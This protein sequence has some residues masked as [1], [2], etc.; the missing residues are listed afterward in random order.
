MRIYLSGVM[1]LIAALIGACNFPAATI[2]SPA[3][4][5]SPTQTTELS[6][7]VASESITEVQPEATPFVSRYSNSEFRISFDYPSS[8]FGP[9]VYVA[10]RTLRIEVGSDVIYP[11]GTGLD[12]RPSSIPNSYVVVIQYTKNDQTPYWSEIYKS[13]DRIQAGETITDARSRIIKVRTLNIGR[14]EGVE[15]IA[16]LSETAQTEPVYT[17]QVILFDDQSNWLTLMGTPS[18]VTIPPGGSWREIFQNIDAANL[19]QFNQ[20]VESLVLQ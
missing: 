15:Y 16:T 5:P 9:E 17:R 7:T 19:W 8:W 1:I 4:P 3:Q 11:Y 10:D 2:E 18:S 12:E 20:L 6:P 13:L 14:F